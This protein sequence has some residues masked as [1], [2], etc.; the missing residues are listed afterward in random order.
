MVG[1]VTLQPLKCRKCGHEWYPRY[2]RL[3]KLCPGCKS[4]KW[5]AKPAWEVESE[6]KPKAE[7]TKN[8]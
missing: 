7:Q 3:P 2:P 8:P 6:V 5:Q 1:E 4:K